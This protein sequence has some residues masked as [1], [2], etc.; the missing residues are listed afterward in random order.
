MTTQF[1]SVVVG[2][3]I[4]DGT[5][6]APFRGSVGISNGTIKCVSEETVAGGTVIDASNCIVAPGFIDA[7][8][9][10]SWGL[11]V[12][13]TCRMLAYQGVTTAVTGNCGGSAFPAYGEAA[14]WISNA[15][16]DYGLSVSWKNLIEY[17]NT[18]GSIGIDVVPLVGH[19]TL[20]AAAAGFSKDPLS[21][22]DLIRLHETLDQCFVEG[23]Y[24]VSF[25][26]AYAPGIFAGKNEL[27]EC[28]KLAASRNSICCFHIRIESDGLIDAV[29]E[30]IELSEKTG[31]RCVICHHKA[32]GRKN[33]G[34]TEETLKLIEE[35]NES[36]C[37][38][39]VDLYPYTTAFRNLA[40]LLPDWAHE[41][42]RS[43]LVKRLN[44]QTLA[45]DLLKGLDANVRAW[46]AAW[47]DTL[48]WSTQKTPELEGI[49]ASTLIQD[50]GEGA[51]LDILAENE[52]RVLTL[53]E[54]ASEND[55]RR[56]AAWPRTVVGS[57]GNAQHIKD[58]GHPRSFATFP[59]FLS[60]FVIRNQVLPLPT[61]IRMMSGRTAE[62]FGLSD[63]GTIETNRRADICI[64]SLDSIEQFADAYSGL[65]KPFPRHLLVRGDTLISNYE[66][67]SVLNGSVVLRH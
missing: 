35:S 28:C 48:I 7:H 41:G 19:G 58:R 6:R 37:D 61:A 52:G 62:A 22:K 50:K 60:Q 57:D 10:V 23:A 33:W 5:G 43:E 46:D 24:G 8:S 42:G 64:F 55:I 36:G 67:T 63:R 34:M 9:N 32:L 3:T 49:L 2:G 30:V 17:S 4:V 66:M 26:L 16:A 47:E 29:Q 15:A 44:D 20:R 54:G 1:D 56:V 27:I 40:T 51:L 21:A 65:H 12:E 13:P 11:M 38:I 59:R 53:Y 45:A 25:G 18:M 31:A 39:F 14:K